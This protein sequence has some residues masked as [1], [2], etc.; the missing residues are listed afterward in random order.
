M[1]LDASGQAENSSVAAREG[2]RV[3]IASGLS[4]GDGSLLVRA[5][6]GGV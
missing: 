5:I 4:R 2:Y 1:I 3:I 6:F